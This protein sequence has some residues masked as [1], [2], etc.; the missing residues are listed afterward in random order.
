[1]IFLIA[2]TKTQKQS[3][4]EI[5]LKQSIPFNDASQILLDTLRTKSSDALRGMMRVSD[6]ILEHVITNLNAFEPIHCALFTFQGAVFRN[7]GPE[8][9]T[10]ETLNYAA[11]HLIILDA[12]Y[13]VIPPYA[14]I[15]HYRLDFTMKWEVDL[16]Q[17]WKRPVTQYLAD[18]D[19]P[20]VSLASK[21]Y[22]RM[23]DPDL[24]S[25]PL[26][27]IDFMECENNICR[28]KSTYAKIAR[29]KMIDYCMR[30]RIDSLEALKDISFD[31]YR[32]SEI[33]SSQG[34]FVYIR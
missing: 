24:L 32:Y 25:H 1:M 16:Y 17:Y 3:E 30:H 8:K 10:Q 20:I 15:G 26:I 7:M 2:P 14:R 13:G 22:H 18:T 28:A 21:E 11:E 34:H 23:I 27:Y 33:H 5:S 9:W 4:S 29:G 19:Q 12:L 6:K 31:G